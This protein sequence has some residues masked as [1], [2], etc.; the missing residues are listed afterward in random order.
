[1]SQNNMESHQIELNTYS[2]EVVGKSTM[3]ENIE[4]A[5]EKGQPVLKKSALDRLSPWRAMLSYKR[6]S[7]VCMMAAFSA[8]LDGY[9]E[10]PAGQIEGLSPNTVQKST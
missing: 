5:L 7:L 6:V 8:S 3:A 2:P 9:R 10:W 1:M 4:T